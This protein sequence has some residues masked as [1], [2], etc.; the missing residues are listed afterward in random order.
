MAE[1]EITSLESLY[2]VLQILHTKHG[3]PHILITSVSLPPQDLESL[4]ISSTSK[5]DGSPLMLLVGSSYLPAAKA[6]ELGGSKG[7][8]P[9]TP[10]LESDFNFN[11]KKGSS[12]KPWFIQFPEIEG[13]FSGVGDTFAALTLGRFDPNLDSSSLDGSPSAIARASELSIASLQGILKNTMDYIE[14]FGEVPHRDEV[15]KMVL[16][17]EDLKDESEIEQEIGGQLKVETMRRRELRIIQSRNEIENPKVKY[18][19]RWLE[20][21]KK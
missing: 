18:R 6:Q 4:G 1:Q 14:S 13:Y 21:V 11:S 9:S 19:A 2:S 12:L 8:Q 15:R 3:A 17:R 7:S 20:V 10:S 16:E 5:E